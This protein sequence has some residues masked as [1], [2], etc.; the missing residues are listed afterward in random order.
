MIHNDEGDSPGQGGR[1]FDGLRRACGRYDL[2]ALP[3][4]A[5]SVMTVSTIGTSSM[6]S[7]VLMLSLMLTLLQILS[8]WVSLDHG[9]GD[10]IGLM[11]VRGGR[12]CRQE[13]K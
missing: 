13:L 12:R 3:L 2:I 8:L 4:Q 1:G 6:T 10:F 7:I 9:S 11:G 5:L